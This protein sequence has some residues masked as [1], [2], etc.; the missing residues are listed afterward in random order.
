MTT[1][2]HDDTHPCV[3]DDNEKTHENNFRLAQ[4]TQRAVVRA[5]MTPRAHAEGQSSCVSTTFRQR[6]NTLRV[7]A[8]AIMTPRAHAEGHRFCVSTTFRQREN[9]Q[10]VVVRALTTR[11]TH[12]EG[13]RFHVDKAK[14]RRGLAFLHFLRR[15]AAAPPNPAPCSKTY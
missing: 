1:S 11:R 2:I 6:E 5:I 12:A 4:N 15:S 13:H 8:R 10:R 9:T 14:T 7:V 3:N